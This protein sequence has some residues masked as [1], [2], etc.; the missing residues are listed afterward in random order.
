[1]VGRGRADKNQVARVI[2]AAFAMAEPPPSDAAD[3]L[4][5]ALTCL[6]TTGFSD[7]LVR[8]GMP[9]AAAARTRRR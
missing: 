3:A 5:V 4:A 1:V 6:A 8:A 7:A 9:A 2:A